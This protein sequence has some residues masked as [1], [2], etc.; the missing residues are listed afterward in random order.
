MN[1]DTVLPDRLRAQ[2]GRKANRRP[3][4]LIYKIAIVLLL[5]VGLRHL[6]TVPHR[7]WQQ[8]RGAYNY[9]TKEGSTLTD[10]AYTSEDLFGSSYRG[11]IDGKDI[12]ISSKNFDDILRL[13]PGS[14]KH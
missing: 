4:K 1:Y 13:I 6:N 5:L 14:G 3:L 12:G 2:L 10:I 7:E 11:K 9:L 8:H